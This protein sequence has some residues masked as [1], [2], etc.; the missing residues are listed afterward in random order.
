MEIKQ[1]KTREWHSDLQNKKKER[2]RSEK[3]NIRD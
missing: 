2:G 3:K 1:I